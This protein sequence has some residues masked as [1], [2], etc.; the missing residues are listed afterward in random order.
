MDAAATSGV[1]RYFQDLPDPR[2]GYLVHINFQ[3]F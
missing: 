3:A 2:T 1:L